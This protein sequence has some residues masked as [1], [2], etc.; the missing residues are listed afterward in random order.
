MAIILTA[1][2]FQFDNTNHKI[3]YAM[4]SNSIKP[5]PRPMYEKKFVLSVETFHAK[6]EQKR[7]IIANKLVANITNLTTSLKLLF[8]FLTGIEKLLFFFR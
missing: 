5:N 2:Y 1:A 4:F 8:L 6:K 3:K 7:S